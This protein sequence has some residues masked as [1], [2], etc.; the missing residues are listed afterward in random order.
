MSS[1]IPSIETSSD[2]PE[3]VARAHVMLTHATSMIDVMLDGHAIEGKAPTGWSDH[4]QKVTDWL[5]SEQRNSAQKRKAIDAVLLSDLEPEITQ[6]ALAA[7]LTPD[8][9]SRW[10]QADWERD[11]A[12]LP[13]VGLYRELFQQRHLAGTKWVPNDLTDMVYL[14][15]GSAYAD[16]VVGERH[17]TSF[18]VQSMRRL[19]RPVN[20][21]PRLRDVIEPLRQRLAGVA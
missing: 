3:E 15:C 9:L 21:Y 16:F 11:V 12:E 14:A 19:S 2:F 17:M 5:R 13:S 10:V 20:V 1:R 18:L 8:D 7:G 4:Q 6:E